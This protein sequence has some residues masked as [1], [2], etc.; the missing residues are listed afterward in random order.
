MILTMQRNRTFVLLL[1]LAGLAACG[2]LVQ[3]G[4]NTP[5]PDSL[6]TLRAT[7]DA[8]ADI[9]ATK[10]T[11]A[12]STPSVPGALQTLR[13]PV[14]TSDTEIA[15]LKGATWVE[16]PS[17][18]FGR[19]LADTIS[20]R[21]GVTVLAGRQ[22]DAGADRQLAGQLLDFG[23]DVRNPAAAVVRVRYDA[24][25]ISRSGKFL[26]ARRFDA[27]AAVGS[28]SPTAV[29]AALNRAANAAA[30]DVAA[31]VAAN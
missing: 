25:L 1:V 31:W 7:G 9:P 30:A 29:G 28:Q 10:T 2:P 19:L 24:T 3:V 4:G 22:L 12:I 14:L 20:K 8:P 15:Y 21:G 6:L 26:A 23:L 17:H 13:L 5:A 18:L 27:S 16:Q 11:L